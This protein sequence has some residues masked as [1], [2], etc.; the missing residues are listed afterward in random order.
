MFLIRSLTAEALTIYAGDTGSELS[1]DHQ[2]IEVASVRRNGAAIVSGC[3][4]R[5]ILHAAAGRVFCGRTPLWE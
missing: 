5:D 1:R 3:E 4:L 2:L